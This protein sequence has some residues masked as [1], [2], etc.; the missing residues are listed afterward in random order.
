M[1]YLLVN[2][3]MTLSVVAFATGYYFRKNVAR[4][5]VWMSLGVSVNLLSAAAL[6]ISIHAFHGGDMIAAGFFPLV[7]PWAVLT[8]RLVASLAAVLMLAQAATG[9]LRKRTWHLRIQKVLIP[10]Y[11]IVYIS[12][13][14]IFTNGP[15]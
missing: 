5:R 11:L 12:G 15:V 3:G 4:H 2:F 14:L 6:V 1:T 7:P 13:L 8:H 9:I 10:L